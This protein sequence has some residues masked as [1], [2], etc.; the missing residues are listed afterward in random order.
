MTRF[1]MFMRGAS[2]SAFL[3]LG[4]VPALAEGKADRAHSAISAAQ[5]KVESANKMG[6]S[7]A[8]PAMMAHAQAEIATAR[9]NLKSG[10]KDVAIEQAIDAQRI[11]DTAIGEANRA[12]VEAASNNVARAQ[13]DAQSQVEAANARA[14]SAVASA[15]DASDRAAAAQ[16]Q[17]AA[18]SAQAEAARNQPTTTVTTVEKS[19]SRTPTR[20]ITHRVV[21]PA[22]SYAGTTTAQQTTTTVSTSNQ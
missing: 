17:A 13:Q 8:S 14:D 18:A 20:R 12:G 10:N 19:S 22:S 9:E 3:A 21:K 11:A 6:A 15:Q 4:A 16:Q 1:S 7:T 5:A 2:V